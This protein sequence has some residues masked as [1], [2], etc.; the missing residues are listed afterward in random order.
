MK[1]L[2]IFLFLLMNFFVLSADNPAHSGTL[3]AQERELESLIEFVPGNLPIILECPHG[4]TKNIPNYPGENPKLGKKDAYAYEL[5][6]LVKEKM[7]QKTGKS[8]TVLAMLGNRNYIE[9]NRKAGPGA[10]REEI[11]QQLY[12]LYYQ[13]VEE[14]I[15]H[16]LRSHKSG[17]MISIH[18]G[19]T[20][21]YEIEIGV[22]GYEKWSTIPFFVKKYSWETFHGPDGIAGRLSRLGYEI[23]GFKG[24]PQTKGWVGYPALTNCRKAQNKGVDGLQFEFY[25]K[26]MLHDPKKREK[27][28]EDL[29]DVLLDFVGKYYAS[30]K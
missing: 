3:S 21:K 4:G 20:M 25:A 23:P 11:T 13:K 5:T 1:F 18:T 17:L 2:M 29:A 15:D 7:M 12:E 30:V 14:G 24:I 27:M 22:N 10:Y 19:W 16:L 28:A 8:P 26:K 9:A 6:Q